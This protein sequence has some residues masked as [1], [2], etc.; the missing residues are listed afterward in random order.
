MHQKYLNLCSQ[1]SHETW[2][3]YKS[4]WILASVKCINVDVIKK[5]IYVGI[6]QQILFWCAG[7]SSICWIWFGEL[8]LIFCITQSTLCITPLSRPQ[9]VIDAE[10]KYNHNSMFCIPVLLLNFV[11]RDCL[12]V[13]LNIDFSVCISHIADS[14]LLNTGHSVPCANHLSTERSRSSRLDPCVRNQRGLR[15]SLG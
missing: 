1:G 9:Y 5:V 11:P 10:W 2:M 8:H 12:K 3:Q 13:D 6:F 4:L 14:V 7:N 15:Q